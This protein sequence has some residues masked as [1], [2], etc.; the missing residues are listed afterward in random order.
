VFAAAILPDRGLFSLWWKQ[1]RVAHGEQRGQ[2]QA[3]VNDF[4]A[5]GFPHARFPSAIARLPSKRRPALSSPRPKQ[6]CCNSITARRTHALWSVVPIR[7][8]VP[9]HIP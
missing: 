2:I 9:P 7:G 8:E 6:N 1:R 4:P 5:L 3:T